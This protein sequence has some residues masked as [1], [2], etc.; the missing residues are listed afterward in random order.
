MLAGRAT[1]RHRLPLRRGETVER[2]LP[3]AQWTRQTAHNYEKNK[4]ALK[5]NNKNE[6]VYDQNISNEP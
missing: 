6:Y 5:Q 2:R 4:K 3:G 1:P